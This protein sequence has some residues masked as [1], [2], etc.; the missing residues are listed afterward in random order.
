MTYTRSAETKLH[1]FTGG[2]TFD[3]RDLLEGWADLAT[4]TIAFLIAPDDVG[5]FWP[6]DLCADQKV[7]QVLWPAKCNPVSIRDG[8]LQ[9]VGVQDLLVECPP[10]CAGDEEGMGGTLPPVEPCLRLPLVSE[11][12]PRCE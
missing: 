5:P 1:D 8:L 12:V 11:S 7:P 3:F 10:R 2:V 4:S 9:V 6:R